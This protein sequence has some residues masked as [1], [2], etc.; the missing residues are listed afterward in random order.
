[1]PL[2]LRL[3]RHGNKHRP[4][5]HIVAADARA[6]RDGRFKDRIGYYNPNQ[7]PSE[8]VINEEKAQYWYGHGAE[9]TNTVGKL[10]RKKNITLTRNKGPKKA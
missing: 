6:P 5:Y 1:M 3:Q 10:L 2:K 8:I 9:V 4:F 7:E